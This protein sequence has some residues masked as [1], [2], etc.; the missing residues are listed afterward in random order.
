MGPGI[1]GLFNGRIVVQTK[2]RTKFKT[3]L[4]K[5]QV[6]IKILGKQQLPGEDQLKDL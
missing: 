3:K 1:I 2:K 5:S 4:V 6:L